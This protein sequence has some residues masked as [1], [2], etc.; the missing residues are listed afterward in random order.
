MST[1]H[2]S[3]IKP[4]DSYGASLIFSLLGLFALMMLI[5]FK[6]QNS[7]PAPSQNNGFMIPP[8]SSKTI[9]LLT[10]KPSAL[11]YV[12]SGHSLE[13]YTSKVKTFANFIQSLGYK[14]LM[15]TPEE[16]DS[17]PK[18][19]ILFAVDAP[20][21][22]DKTK[23]RLY[24]FTQNGGNLFFN[25]TTGFSDDKGN[26]LGD[27]FTH[28][29]TGLHLSKRL[30]FISFKNKN[31][32]SLFVTPK[33]LSPFSTY[34]NTGDSLYVVL[35]DKIPI[36]ET[37]DT[38]LPDLFATSY[39]QATPPIA[40]Q[41]DKSLLTKEAGMAWHG[42]LGK[43]K[44]VYTTMPSYSFYDNSEQKE[45]FKKLLSGM[46]HYLSEPIICQRYPFIDNKGAIFISEDTEYKFTNFER[47]ADLAKEYRF[48]VTAFIVANLAQKPEHRAMMERIAQNPYVEFAS[49]STSHQQI[50]G[51][52]E[53]YII[54]ET[55]GS[56]KIIDQFAK[57]PIQGFRPPREELNELMKK[58]LAKSGFTYI[59]G[60]TQEHLYPRFDDKEPNLLIIPRH[61]TDDFSYLV[62]LDWDQQQI[63]DQMIREAH[64][65]TTLNGIYTLS[66]HTHL[67]TYSTNINILKKFFHYLSQHPELK[68]IGGK[69]LYKKVYL[70]KNLSQKL[71]R[72]DK[73]YILTIQ[74]KN[75]QPV[76]DLYIQIFK[77][78]T[79][80][81][82]HGS[83]DT[84]SVKV[85]IDNNQNR[86]HLDK[87]PA[88]TTVHIYFTLAKTEG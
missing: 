34:L 44:W 13:E 56:K 43:G 46:I 78:P 37:P 27:A 32:G 75:R 48:P 22:S 77:N 47:F 63:V 81:I 55:A 83:I 54:N 14:T 28:K 15:T 52:D 29:V 2:I 17:L 6:M 86:I 1:P 73:Q 82:V 12:K 20:A 18:D 74:N 59:L 33:L 41:Q 23:K 26:Y 49:H 66:V 53:N 69:A 64:F 68:I 38:L 16:I 19:A 57:D 51:K 76:E 71:E 60:A 72:K 8:S 39:S 58:H 87:I 4:R 65:V 35:Y 5:L 10:S 7:E 45:Q 79:T 62:N 25:F 84:K 42:Y 61:G 21:L 30:G 50:V 85:K 11:L 31:E 88:D 67:F 9:Y 70:A 24:E 3:Y 36:F 40:T 80:Q